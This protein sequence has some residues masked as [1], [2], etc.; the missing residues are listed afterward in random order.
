MHR[1]LSNYHEKLHISR[2]ASIFL[3][4]CLSTQCWWWIFQSQKSQLVSWGEPLTQTMIL[5]DTNC[6]NASHRYVPWLCMSA[7]AGLLP[8]DQNMP[9]RTSSGTN[10]DDRGQAVHLGPD[11]PHARISSNWEL[12]VRI[13]KED[14]VQ[15]LESQCSMWQLDAKCCLLWQVFC[16]KYWLHMVSCDKEVYYKKNFKG[17][18]KD[19]SSLS[20][21][22]SSS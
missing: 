8:L 2:Q 21:T 14:F 7:Y 3:L 5:F 16:K 4:I 13:H 1:N 22:S 11:H 17:K 10:S 19:V 6:L 15:R 20:L 9:Y 12:I 18:S